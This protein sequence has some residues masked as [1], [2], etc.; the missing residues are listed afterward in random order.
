MNI[1]PYIARPLITTVC[2]T[3]LAGYFLEAPE[4]TYRQ[5]YHL[6]ERPVQLADLAPPALLTSSSMASGSHSGSWGTISG[7]YPANNCGLA[8]IMTPS[9]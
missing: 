5:Q 4:P 8:P 6:P 3:T 7:S 2:V 9:G 1:P